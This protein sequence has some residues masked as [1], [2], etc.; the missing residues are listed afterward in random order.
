M[1]LKNDLLK[2]VVAA[3]KLASQ[4]PATQE[5]RRI[6]IGFDKVEAAINSL[7]N[8]PVSMDDVKKSVEEEAKQEEKPVK[9]TRAKK[10]A[11]KKTS[12]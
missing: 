11:A 5:R 12:K 8:E 2:V 4:L 7:P 6:E 10:T 3:G 1:S 9:T